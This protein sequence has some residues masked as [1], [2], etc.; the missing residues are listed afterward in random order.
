MFFFDIDPSDSIR[1]PKCYTIFNPFFDDLETITLNLNVT[2]RVALSCCILRN[3]THSLLSIPK[4]DYRY[5]I[6]VPQPVDEA[7]SPPRRY[8]FKEHNESWFRC[9][10][11]LPHLPHI[12]A[13]CQHHSLTSV[14]WMAYYTRV[15]DCLLSCE[16][17][18]IA[19]DGRI[20]NIVTFKLVRDVRLVNSYQLRT[21]SRHRVQI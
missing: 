8:N 16:I 7:S 18:Y 1:L 15:C 6:H 19:V 21:N 3:T 13:C 20:N 14:T 12:K 11:S 2:T 4:I 5:H 10:W 9:K 17:P